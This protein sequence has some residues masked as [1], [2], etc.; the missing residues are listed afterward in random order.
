MINDLITRL[1]AFLFIALFSS[2]AAI[3]QDTTVQYS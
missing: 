3:A 1:I 2:L